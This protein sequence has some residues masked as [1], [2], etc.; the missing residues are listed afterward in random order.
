M[1]NPDE[2]I[3][4]GET[5]AK[6]AEELPLPGLLDLLGDST[7]SLSSLKTLLKLSPDDLALDRMLDTD[8]IRTG[9]ATGR[10]SG[11]EPFT[12]KFLEGRV[13]F[14]DLQAADGEVQPVFIHALGE[15]NGTL[16]EGASDRLR[17]TTAGQLISTNL[18]DTVPKSVVR[19][20]RFEPSILTSQ[21]AQLDRLPQL[22][23]AV[24]RSDAE[25]FLSRI[26]SKQPVTSMVTQDVGDSLTAAPQF[27]GLS[28]AQITRELESAPQTAEP[29]E[30]AIVEREILGDGDGR[31][32]NFTISGDPEQQKIW[33]VDLEQAFGEN[34]IPA[35]DNA[36]PYHDLAG[37]PL[38]A[39]TVAQVNRFL[40]TY[41]TDTGRAAMRNA[42]LTAP[43]ADATVARARWFAQ[44]QIYPRLT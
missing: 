42:G 35:W 12:W 43:E 40:R 21:A 37:Q 5:V 44:N 7:Q 13:A 6:V 8:G 1:P 39:D 10:I 2:L 17:K 14:G 28:Q 33:N 38:Q 31:L 22:R 26:L 25:S 4:A 36:Y 9:L 3:L 30:R 11:V 20:L 27:E 34:R 24:A 18:F 29:F 15:P 19:D 41:G 32:E 16:W 23:D